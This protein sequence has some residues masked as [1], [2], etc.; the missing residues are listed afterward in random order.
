MNRNR[1]L[2]VMFLQ[3]IFSRCLRRLVWLAGYAITLGCLFFWL[4]TGQPTDNQVN[5][6]CGSLVWSFV[7]MIH[8]HAAQ[9]RQHFLP[10]CRLMLWRM[11]FPNVIMYTRLYL[12]DSWIYRDRSFFYRLYKQESVTPRIGLDMSNV[13]GMFFIFRE[14]NH[15]VV[16]S[17]KQW[18]VNRYLCIFLP[19][20]YTNIK[21]FRGATPMTLA[22]VLERHILGSRWQIRHALVLL[23]WNKESAEIQHLTSIIYWL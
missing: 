15:Y 17:C 1:Y 23:C 18:T 8:C 3:H 13:W 6:L 19:V 9:I 12:S 7:L 20:S 11:T 14:P 5:T 22:D 2:S 4:L 16:S 10:V 21:P